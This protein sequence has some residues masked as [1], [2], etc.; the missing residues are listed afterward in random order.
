MNIFSLYASKDRKDQFYVT[1]QH[2]NGLKLSI[3]LK[4]RGIE[5]TFLYSMTWH[6]SCGTR[7]SIDFIVYKN[8]FKKK[9]TVYRPFLVFLL[10][11]LFCLT[12]K[13]TFL[14]NNLCFR[15]TF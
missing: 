4:S 8:Y 14:R 13:L 6:G 3:V 5:H 2:D 12:E 15:P 9:G 1:F 10:F 7:L 11:L